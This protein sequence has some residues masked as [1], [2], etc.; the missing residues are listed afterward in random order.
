MTKQTYMILCL[1]NLAGV[2]E[3]AISTFQLV[4]SLSLDVDSNTNPPV[5]DMQCN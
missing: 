2:N 4:P 3:F 1:L 5:Y